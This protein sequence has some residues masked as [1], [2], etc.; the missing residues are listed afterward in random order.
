MANQAKL[1][2]TVLA[3]TLL[4]SILSLAIE[5][6]PQSYSLFKRGLVLGDVTYS[7]AATDMGSANGSRVKTVTVI[8]NMA[9]PK[10]TSTMFTDRTDQFFSSFDD[11]TGVGGG[12]GQSKSKQNE[13]VQ[14]WPAKESNKMKKVTLQPPVFSGIGISSAAPEIKEHPQEEFK[15]PL[16]LLEI[17][18]SAARTQNQ[19][20]GTVAGEDTGP[21][22]FPADA[23]M[24]KKRN[25]GVVTVAKDYTSVVTTERS[26]PKTA[27]KLNT[28]VESKS[29]DPPRDSFNSFDPSSLY[30][31]EFEQSE[32]VYSPKKKEFTLKQTSKPSQS[33]GDRIR[34][35]PFAFRDPAAPATYAE[36]A[37][38]NSN[39]T[40]PELLF[41][42]LANAVASRNISMI[43]NLAE[44][45]DD[46]DRDVPKY[47]FESL[48]TNDEYVPLSKFSFG[49]D[50]SM[51]EISDTPTTS[52]PIMPSTTMGTTTTIEPAPVTTKKPLK[53]IAPR[54]RGFKRFSS[55]RQ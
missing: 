8:K 43:K 46:Q 3:V 31:D 16:E 36:F 14:Y 41:S 42:E 45:L 33:V 9:L 24:S 37:L 6:P 15:H 34:N 52:E 1:I 12:H 27:G 53:Y 26:K 25:N 50:D 48:K 29:K 22:M 10:A 55:R 19:L 4:P 21:H 49:P 39:Q 18:K 28:K 35:T 11:V 13:H 23:T 54:L 51:M 30:Q 38:Y 7:Y 32:Y 17:A 2:V 20:M 40:T 47:E 44:Q 5:H